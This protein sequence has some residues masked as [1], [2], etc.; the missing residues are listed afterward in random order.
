MDKEALNNLID[1]K[2]EYALLEKQLEAS[3]DA[4]EVRNLFDAL[5]ALKETI[6]QLEIEIEA[7]EEPKE[8]KPAEA[9]ADEK[10]AEDEKAE[11]K[12]AD[13]KPAEDEKKEERS[14]FNPLNSYNLGKLNKR[15]N[16]N[17][18][19]LRSSIEYRSAFK[20][21]VQKGVVA[22]PL[23]F[24]N[25]ST[26]EVINYRADTPITSGDLG[27]LLPQTIIQEVIAE[28]EGSY[29]QLYSR[30]RK[31]NIAGGVK[32]PVGSLNA[33]FKRIAEGAAP[34]DRQ[35][36]SITG[37]VTFEYKLGE[38]RISQTLLASIVSVDAF[39]K[40]IAKSIVE[41]YLKAMDEEILN[42]NDSANQCEGILTNVSK[43]PAANVIEFT[44]DEMKDW[45]KINKKL[46]A[47]VPLAVRKEKPEFAV[48][49]G[50]YEG[51]L[52]SL[53]DNNNTPLAKEVY[54]IADGVET[55]MFNNK[56]VVF[57]EEGLGLA[58]F[59]DAANG[60]YFGMYW[61]PSKAY[62]INTNL[63][64]ATKRYFDEE[65]NEWVNKAIT[66]NDGK[67]LDSSYIYLLKKKVSG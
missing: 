41:A 24:R 36:L 9:P 66:I 3:Q 45:T 51:N 27:V 14:G 17:M 13:E 6:K 60:E 53:A 64:F 12:P 32:I 20:D 46:F 30:V 37:A 23:Q 47:K 2:T 26:N 10:P 31:F 18:D 61:V 1:K 35:K 15:G 42:G 50:T 21:F 67:I 19:N 34:S 40:E 5:A 25:N 49:V 43:I 55:A 54:S 65:K 48:T 16:D 4:A 56:E 7:A 52:K 8:D 11:D 59:D 63:E 33:S 58:N 44:E 57:V 28:L 38:V 29:G 22:E 39:E 62:G